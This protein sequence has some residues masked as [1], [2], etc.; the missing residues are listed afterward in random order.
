MAKYSFF[1][2]KCGTNFTVNVPYEEK[3]NAE[4]PKCGSKD[5]RPDYSNVRLHRGTGSG[6][7]D[8]DPGS[9]CPSIGGPCG[10]GKGG[11]CHE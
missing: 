3:E 4:C 8:I 10:M 6:Y 11:S 9:F 5:K 1:C 2:N 7:E